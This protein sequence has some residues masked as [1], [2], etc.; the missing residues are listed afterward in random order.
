ME[1]HELVC[2]D[3]IDKLMNIYGHFHDG[4]IK[5]IHYISGAY[6]GDNLSM[7]PINTQRILKVIFHRQARNPAAIEVEFSKLVQF[8]LKPVDENY[9]TEIFG[10]FMKY[11]NGVIY[12]ADDDSWNIESEDKSEY[13]WIAASHVRWRENNNYLS[14]EIIYNNKWK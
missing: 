11:I 14:D 1:W 5:E 3:D 13:T 2:Q 8:N 4:C 10:T 12:W 6:V 7:M 9:T